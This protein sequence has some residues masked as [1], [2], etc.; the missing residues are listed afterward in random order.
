ME[1]ETIKKITNRLYKTY[2]ELELKEVKIFNVK[3]TDYQFTVSITPSKKMNLLEVT[4]GD[5]NQIE[6]IVK[7]IPFLKMMNDMGI[8]CKFETK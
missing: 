6:K 3:G 5:F 2:K 7:A 4:N 1:L 8:K